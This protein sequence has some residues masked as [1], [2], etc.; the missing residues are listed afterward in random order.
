MARS[1]KRD[2]NLLLRLVEEVLVLG[3]GG[4]RVERESRIRSTVLG[5]GN[6]EGVE[7]D[8]EEVEGGTGK[9]RARR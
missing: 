8:V 4:R 1:E 6:E 5:G 7:M 2:R 3:L 9:R